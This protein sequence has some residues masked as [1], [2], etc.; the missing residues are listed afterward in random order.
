M[1]HHIASEELVAV[2]GPL[3]VGPLMGAEHH[4]AKAALAQFD[5]PLDA[6]DDS[7]GRADK[8][9][10]RSHPVAQRI[11]REARFAAERVLEISLGLDPLAGPDLA[12]G[13]LV[14]FGDM[15]ADDETPVPALHAATVLR[16]GFLRDPPLP[17]QCLRT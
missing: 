9:G 15:H 2:P 6:F 16:R 5:E 1:R 13:L 12:Q 8:G 4:A 7:L 11:V 3:A 17:G 14:V 10:A